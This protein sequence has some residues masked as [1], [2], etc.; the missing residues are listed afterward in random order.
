[1]IWG[2]DELVEEAFKLFVE[3]LSKKT[4]KSYNEILIKLELYTNFFKSL[5][6]DDFSPFR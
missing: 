5:K 3:K 2:D 6:I 1:M 4:G